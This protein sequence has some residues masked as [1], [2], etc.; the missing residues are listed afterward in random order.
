MESL[1]HQHAEEVLHQSFHDMLSG[2]DKA[3]L[4]RS[5]LERL[6]EDLDKSASNR[7]RGIL[8]LYAEKNIALYHYR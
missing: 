2:G 5:R 1:L 4:G 3:E 7:I 8:S 6:R